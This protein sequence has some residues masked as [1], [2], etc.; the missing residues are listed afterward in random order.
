MDATEYFDDLLESVG[1]FQQFCG[2][3][4]KGL[5]A[6]SV[7]RLLGANMRS[8]SMRTMHDV[9]ANL[10][11]IDHRTPV[12][13]VGPASDSWTLA[14]EPQSYRGAEPDRL[15]NLSSGNGQ[16]INIHWTV[17]L[18]SGLTLAENG[19][20]ITGLSL[21]NPYV[22]REGENPARLDEQLEAFGLVA[23]RNFNEQVATAF[24]LVNRLTGFML[25][26]EWF[27]TLQTQ[28]LGEKR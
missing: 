26:S 20:I 19:T 15:R 1:L 10:W 27:S 14:I 8:K 21:T 17:N 24:L 16:A 7:A 22:D 11:R 25:N 6:D 28:Y 3:W 13:L 4:T 2:T 5:Q 12:L 18:T 9:N 23:G